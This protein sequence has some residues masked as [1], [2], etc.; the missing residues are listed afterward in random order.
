MAVRYV[1]HKEQRLVLTIGHGRVTFGEL[2]AHR[3][4]LLRDP[5]FNPTFNQLNDYSAATSTDLSQGNVHVFASTSVFSPASRR[6][7]VVLKPQ[8]FGIARQFEA[9]HDER[10]NVGVFYDWQSALKWLELSDISSP[11]GEGRSTA[12]RR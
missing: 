3:R 10:A 9:Y 7:V 8:F 4:Q 2:L 11:I 1:I 12:D 5:N 6:A